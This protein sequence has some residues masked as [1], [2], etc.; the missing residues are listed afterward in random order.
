MQKI[1][2]F[3]DFCGVSL[4]KNVRMF[5]VSNE[6]YDY[7]HHDVYTTNYKDTKQVFPHLCKKCAGRLD[8]MFERMDAIEESNY[9]MMKARYEINKKRR[10]RLNSKG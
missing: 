8:Y 10:N 7:T 4:S 6:T 1:E 9:K 2:L 5:D 3:C